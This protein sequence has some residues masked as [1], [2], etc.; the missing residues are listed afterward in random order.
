MRT[1]ILALV[2]FLT[3]LARLEVPPNTAPVEPC[4]D[5]TLSDLLAKYEA[6]MDAA[7][8]KDAIALGAAV[9]ARDQCLSGCHS[10][11]CRESCWQTYWLKERAAFRQHQRDQQ[12]CER[13]FFDCFDACGDRVFWSDADFSL[14]ESMMVEAAATGNWCWWKALGCI[15]AT[16][17]EYAQCLARGQPKAQCW[18]MLNTQLTHCRW[19]LEACQ[20]GPVVSEGQEVDE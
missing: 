14:I 11:S 9:A 10:A 8:D 16:N 18:E 4:G 12:A 5:C 20:G 7:A 2:L 1:L 3:P 17:V 6:C 13:S 19:D 15:A